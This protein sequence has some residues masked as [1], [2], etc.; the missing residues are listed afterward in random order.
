MIGCYPVS[1]ES[2]RGELLLVDVNNGFEVVLAEEFGHVEPTGSSPN[3]SEGV[4]HGY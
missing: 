1:Q 3:D 2:K 4:S